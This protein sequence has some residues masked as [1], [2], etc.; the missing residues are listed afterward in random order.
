VH[1]ATQRLGPTANDFNSSKAQPLLMIQLA[2]PRSKKNNGECR[3]IGGI[4]IDIESA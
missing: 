1:V 2:L 4:A 3:N